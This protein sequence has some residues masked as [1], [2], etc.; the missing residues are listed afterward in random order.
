EAFHTLEQSR[1]QSFLAQLAERDLGF[2]AAL[3]HPQPLRAKRVRE[4]LDP[5]TVMLSYS[6]G[7]EQ[8]DLFVVSRAHGLSV[9]TVDAGEDEL[10]REVELFRRLIPRAIPGDSFGNY[11]FERLRDLGRHLYSTLIAPVASN[12]QQH[13]RVLIIP[14]G[15]LHLLPFGALIRD[16]TPGSPA[17][18]WQY[19]VEWKPLHSA[20][21]ATVYAE[22]K[23]SRRPAPSAGGDT[24]ISF[25]AFG[26]PHY[27]RTLTRELH[28]SGG[29]PS[30]VVDRGAL[31]WKPLPHTRREVEQIAELFPAEAIRIYLGEDAT[32]ARV[33]AIGRQPRILHI[34]AHGHLDQRQPLNSF[35]ALTISEELGEDRDN[36][37]LQVWEI[38]ERVRLDADLVVLS[39]CR[40]ALGKDLGGEGLLGL[41]RAFQYAGARSVAATL[42]SVQDQTTAELMV[43][44]YRQLNA[45]KATAEALRAA[46]IEL[47]QGT[48]RVENDEGQIVERDASAPYY[49]A[50]FQ[51]YGDWK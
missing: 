18:G 9:E 41:T 7:E 22:L 17:R 10:R 2:D 42:W 14:D 34:A 33:K 39:A 8:T 31:G 29:Q 5:G 32:E 47:I 16:T 26:D 20:I 19:L 48:I 11:D 23:S 3:R 13:D 24:R 37:L 40:S 46:Q 6:V 1:A 45:D 15:P 4:I 38:F 43:R 12:I 51:I 25:A 27:P 21:S 50:A 36:G 30:S 44:F 35:I 49:W 28:H